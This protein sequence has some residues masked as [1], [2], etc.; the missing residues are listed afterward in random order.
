MS[1]ILLERL[2]I[3]FLEKFSLYLGMEILHWHK[4]VNESWKIV[5]PPVSQPVNQS[6]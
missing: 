6:S 3:V 5:A 4:M 2:I 1:K